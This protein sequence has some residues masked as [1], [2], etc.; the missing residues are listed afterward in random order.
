MNTGLILQKVKEYRNTLIIGCFV[1][2][3]S[4]GFSENSLEGIDAVY[5]INLDRRQDRLAAA[6]AALAEYG[7]CAKRFSAVEGGKIPLKTLLDSALPYSSAMSRDHWAV[8]PVKNGTLGYEFLD[9]SAEGKP[10]FSEWMTIGAVGCALSHLSVLQEAYDAGLETIW[11]LEDDI[12]FKE[13]PRVLT[14]LIKDLDVLTERKWDIL[15]T[16]SDSFGGE[17]QP[18]GSFWWMWRPDLALFDLQDFEKRKCVSKDLIQVKHRDR[19]HSMVIRRSGM[20][21]VLD[22]IKK[23]HLYLP[24]DLEI[25]FASDMQLF[26]T[27]FPI[28]TYNDTDSDIQ[29]NNLSSVIYG[30]NEWEL[31]KKSRLDGLSTFSGWCDEIKANRLMDFIYKHRPSL[32]VEIGT[33]DGSTTFPLISALEYLNNGRLFTIDAWNNEDAVTGVNR[34]NPNYS[35][36][37]KVDFDRVKTAFLSRFDNLSKRERPGKL[38]KF[39]KVSKPDKLPKLTCPYKAGIQS[40]C[41]VLNSTSIQAASSFQD[42]SIDLLYVDG[43]F[44]KAGSL[45]DIITYFPKVKEGGFIWLNDANFPEKLPS[46]AF[47]CEYAVFLKEESLKNTCVVFQKQR[48]P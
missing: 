39:G 40:R 32:C 17:S 23:N 3:A 24:I 48:K 5:L 26:M 38:D 29:T 10:V 25:A 28:V 47:L 21:K 8:T 15:Y 42:G 22:H 6:T 43:N 12:C 44:S 19:T 37:E 2:F 45:Q 4:F 30:T 18:P 11:V 16:D 1:F 27:S 14:R 20:K 31:Y 9:V 41:T 36:W 13:D 46:V 35:W 34:C 33:Y 7:L